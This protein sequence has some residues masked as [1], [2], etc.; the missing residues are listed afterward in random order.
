MVSQNAAAKTTTLKNALLKAASDLRRCADQLQAPPAELP[1]G[2][3]GKGKGKEKKK[4]EPAAQQPGFIA[5]NG[6]KLDN[7]GA[8]RFAEDEY[9]LRLTAGLSPQDRERVA[10]DLERIIARHT[11]PATKFYEDLVNE[12]CLV[13]IQSSSG[14]KLEI[15]GKNWTS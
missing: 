15:R 4:G 3:M 5:P 8:L 10:T 13:V 12:R 14:R 1:R 6:E 11:T 9:F 2:W 7:R